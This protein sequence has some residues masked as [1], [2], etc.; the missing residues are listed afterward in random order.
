MLTSVSI[1][2]LMHLSMQSPTASLLG[3][4]GDPGLEHLLTPM[5][6]PRGGA[7]AYSTIHAPYTTLCHMGCASFRIAYPERTLAMDESD[8]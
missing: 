1:I 7:F 8:H 2:A 4:R 6:C 3:D 5:S